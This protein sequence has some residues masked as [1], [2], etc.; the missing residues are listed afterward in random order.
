MRY[1]IANWPYVGE[2]FLEHL[3]LTLSALLIAT[4]IALPVG[5]I[6]SRVAWLRTPVLGILGIIYTIPSLSLLVLLIPFLRL[7]YRPALVTLIAYAQLVL[8]RSVVVGINGI[9]PAIIEAAKGMGMNS[10]Q[11]LLRV[12]LPLALPVMIAGLRV[13]TLSTIAIATVAAFVNAGGLGTLLFDGV[14]SS[15]S[16]KIIAGAI[17]VSLLAVAA[18]ILFRRAEIWA[19]RSRGPT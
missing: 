16:E 9:E 10:W 1:L 4:A 19:T 14:R 15:N 11:R 3:W 5:V 8:V 17:S 2:L 7:G 6:L 13:A 12:E 18:N